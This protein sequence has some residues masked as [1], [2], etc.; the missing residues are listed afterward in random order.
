MAGTDAKA[1]AG[2]ILQGIGG[3]LTSIAPL[4]TGPW[5]LALAGIGAA[6]SFT[7][8]LVEHGLDPVQTIT[9][10]QSVLPDYNA[11]KGRLQKLIDQRAKP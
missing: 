2:N 5:A 4:T 8:E 6:V 9:E 11:A 7:A 3:A 1:M 10:I